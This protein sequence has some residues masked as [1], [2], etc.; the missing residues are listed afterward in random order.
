M[1]TATYPPGIH[2]LLSAP[3]EIILEIIY[4]LSLQ[5]VT[6]LRKVCAS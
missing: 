4:Y 3:D 1:E 6:A 5:E 2:A